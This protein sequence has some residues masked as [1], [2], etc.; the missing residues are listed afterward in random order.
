MDFVAEI[1]LGY[2]DKMLLNKIEKQ[3]LKS[4][5]YF[6]TEMITEFFGSKRSS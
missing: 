2:A 5:K 4:S 6:V 3:R 1:V